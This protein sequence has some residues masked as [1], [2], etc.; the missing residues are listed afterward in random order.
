MGVVS[1]RWV[2]LVGEIYECGW[3]VLLWLL[4]ADLG[5]GK[6]GF[7]VCGRRPHHCCRQLL[8]KHPS[9]KFWK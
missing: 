4:V 6:E 5:F 8:R 3:N 7:E 2:W 1:R 9:M